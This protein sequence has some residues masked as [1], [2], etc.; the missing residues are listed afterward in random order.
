MRYGLPFTPQAFDNIPIIVLKSQSVY[1]LA[2]LLSFCGCNS[3]TSVTL[4][5]YGEVT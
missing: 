5:L 4:L 3:L 2:E 1:C